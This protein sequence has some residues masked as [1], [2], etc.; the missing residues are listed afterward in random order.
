MC[1]HDNEFPGKFLRYREL[2]PKFISSLAETNVL[3]TKN[4]LHVKAM[5]R[6]TAL[7][8]EELLEVIDQCPN[9]R[10]L[11][12]TLRSKSQDTDRV[13]LRKGWNGTIG[14][15]SNHLRLTAVL[16]GTS[17][18]KLVQVFCVRYAP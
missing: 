14:A 6:N 7:E 11:D 13:R 15:N 4:G 12:T 9:V 16:L 5:R 1:K 8:P 2:L 10:S 18:S 3:G 17:Y